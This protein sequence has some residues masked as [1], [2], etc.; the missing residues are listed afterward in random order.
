MSKIG[1]DKIKIGLFG[2]G[3]D[4][5]WEQ[6]DGL[7]DRLLGYQNYIADRIFKLE[8]EV[9]NAGM[10]DNPETAR[11]TGDFFREKKVEVIFLYISTYALSHTVLPIV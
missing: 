2:I 6:F 4:T 1:T 9:I 10:V 7:H 5:Y 11:K 3:L 8:T